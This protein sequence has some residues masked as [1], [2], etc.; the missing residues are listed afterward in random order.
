MRN[1]LL[2]GMAVV[3]IAV[4]G[5]VLQ[6]PADK[7]QAG[8]GIEAPIGNAAA[9][10][11]APVNVIVIIADDVGVDQIAAYEQLYEYSGEVAHPNPCTPVL[12]ALA[13][14]GMR[15]TN[16]WS[17]PVCTPTRSQ[18]MTGRRTSRSGMG[19]VTTPT[20]PD[21]PGLDENI[22]TIGDLVLYDAAVGK[23]HL[24]DEDQKPDHPCDLGFED[25]LGTYYNLGTPPGDG[26][27][28]YD[29]QRWSCDSPTAEP[30]TQ[31]A[32]AVTTDDAIA[33]MNTMEANAGASPWLLY[34]SY[35][36]AHGPFHCPEAPDCPGPGSCTGDW[37]DVCDNH[38]GIYSENI[39]KTRAMVRAMDYQIGR[40]LD[41]VDAVDPNT[42]IIFIGDNGTPGRATHL[43]FNKKHAKAS[44]YQGGVNVPLIIRA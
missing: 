21:R 29:W 23:W 34:V 36:A 8:D 1:R 30:Q 10:D 28:Y 3:V 22:F 5:I 32:T 19:S 43:P 6:A 12:D 38:F 31:Y 9:S 24:A 7:G 37:C 41:E 14:S 39:R 40:L 27:G 17:N 15:F 16:A 18:I 26:P 2:A 20:N 25:F 33:F 11:P 35:H 4:M 13:G 42:A 44:V